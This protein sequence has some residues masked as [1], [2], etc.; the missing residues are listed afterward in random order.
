MVPLFAQRYQLTERVG[1]GG[2]GQVWSAWDTRLHRKVAVKIV[3]LEGLTDADR[4][5]IVREA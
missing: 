5:R 3:H 2:M 1:A 4:Q